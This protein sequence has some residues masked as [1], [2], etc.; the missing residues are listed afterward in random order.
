M[1]CVLCCMSCYSDSKLGSRVALMRCMQRTHKPQRQPWLSG[2]LNHA[3]AA[4]E[5]KEP[6]FL[7]R[8]IIA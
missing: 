7:S 6:Y 5:P 2:L 3:A 8:A 1:C 4:H